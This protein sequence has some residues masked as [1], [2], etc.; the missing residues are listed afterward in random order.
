MRTSPLCAT[1]RTSRPS[2]EAN[3]AKRL[4]CPPQA[5]VELSG[6]ATAQSFLQLRAV[7]VAADEDERALP[8]LARLPGTVHPAIELHVNPLED[9]PARVALDAEDALHPK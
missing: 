4:V 3:R 9:E 6:K 2:C 7:E 5:G 1:G 8:R